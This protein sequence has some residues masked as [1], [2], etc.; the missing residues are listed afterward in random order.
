MFGEKLELIT[1]QCCVCKKMVAMRV[2][3]DDT[4]RFAGGVLVRRAFVKRTGEQYLSA[5]ERELFLSG[6]CDDCWHLL[7]ES[8]P[9]AYD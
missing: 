5:G 3:R 9:L 2:D 6:C 1:R 8:D 4:D 7:C